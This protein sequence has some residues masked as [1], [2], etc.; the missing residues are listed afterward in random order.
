MRILFVN[1]GGSPYGGAERSL[2]LLVRGLVQHGHDVSVALLAE[3]AAKHLFAEAG[4]RVEVIS[5]ESLTGVRRHGTALAF[6]VGSA[7]SLPALAGTVRR[8][9]ALVARERPDLVHTNGFRAH[10]TSPLV[11]SRQV[12]SLRD[13]APRAVQ[14]RVLRAAARSVSG[15]AANSLFTAAQVRGACPV[16]EVVYN[17]VEEM[18]LPSREEARSRLAVPPGRRV[19]AIVA[20]LHA[21]KGHHVALDALRRFPQAERPFLIC[22][23]GALYPDSEAYEGELRE[24]ITAWDLGED[25][26][27]L[28]AVDDVAGIYAAADVLLHPVLHPEGLGRAAI[29]AQR[30]GVP[31]VASRLGG[32]LEVVAH[33]ETGLLVEPSRPDQIADALRS[34]L[35]NTALSA[36]LTNAARVSSRRFDPAEHAQAMMRF[37]RRVLLR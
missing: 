10:V 15:I 36:R 28:G 18:L 25:V 30:A 16:V 27:L 33:D 7:R 31:V 24:R 2:G 37:Y 4:A 20:H 11:R 12:W 6:A 3:G 19:V 26:R 32:M 8:L 13:V 9:R 22:A 35:R 29:E 1:P 21:S 5:G 14:R 17:P 23:G 34:L